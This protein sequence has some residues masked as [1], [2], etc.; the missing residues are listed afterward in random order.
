MNKMYLLDAPVL[1][2]LLDNRKE[3]LEISKSYNSHKELL[4]DFKAFMADTPIYLTPKSGESADYQVIDN[5]AYIPIVG[6]LT[7]MAEKD[8]CGAYTSEALTEYGY[9]AA[10]SMAA[11]A[12]EAV[13]KIVYQV[14]SPGGYADGIMTAVTAMRGVSK[15][16]EAIVEGTAASA[17]YWLASQTDKIIASSEM[18]RVGSIGVAVEEY[19]NTQQ[20]E[21][22]GITRRVY[23]S[24]DAPDKRLDT[25]TEDGQQKV[26]DRLD[27]MHRVFVKYVADGRGTTAEE[28]NANYGRGGVLL[29]EE[30]M[31]R[32]MIDEIMDMPSRRDDNIA[33]VVSSDTAA[34]AEEKTEEVKRVEN[35]TL[36][37]LKTQA[38][39]LFAEAVKIGVEKERARVSE[40]RTYTEADPDNMKLAEVINTAIA[41]GS[42]LSQVNAKIQVAIRDGGR[43]SGEN[44]ASVETVE[45]EDELSQEDNA[46]LESLRKSGV[47]MTEEEF[48]K[49]KKEVK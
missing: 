12:D 44:A 31:R 42:E 46:V 19:D 29:A 10:A 11:D 36:E 18:V 26:V 6:E 43:L 33:D 14:N 41:D 17:A 16:T 1:A 25:R 3:L 49:Y 15:P 9:I 5:V 48:K 4:E 24:T 2:E 27:D 28:V 39:G 40:L 7:P 34:T 23:T 45:T 21:N 32:G 8:I 22:M 37:E 47:E 13:E 20:L 30:A 38:P 35:I